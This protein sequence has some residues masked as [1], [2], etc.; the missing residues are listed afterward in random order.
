MKVKGNAAMD[1]ALIYFVKYP[2]PGKVKTRLARTLGAEAAAN[3]YRGLAEEIFH[4]LSNGI[5]KKDFERVVF[6]DPPEK[7]KD[8]KE[9]LPGAAAYR[10]QQ[11]GDLGDRLIQAFQFAFDCGAGQVLALGSDTLGFKG[12]LITRAFEALENH[13]VTLGPAKDGGY[14]LIGLSEPYDCFFQD[15]PWSTSDVLKT[16]LGRIREE[17]LSHYFLPQLDDLDEIKIQN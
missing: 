11:G 7:E 9:W 1:K 6:F 10:P 12:E 14:Y 8:V 16:T 5:K 2:E 17:G 15:I 13:D 3:A 4:T